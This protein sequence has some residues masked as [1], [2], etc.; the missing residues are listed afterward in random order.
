MPDM[1]LF[2][3]RKPPAGGTQPKAQ[4]GI[5]P[6]KKESL[7]EVADRGQSIEAKKERCP[8]QILYFMHVTATADLAGTEIDYTAVIT[9]S[10]VWICG[11]VHQRAHG[12]QPRISERHLEKCG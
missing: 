6:V 8:R 5:L 7:V 11:F 2:R 3:D 10:K 1:A 9:L 4:I 12:S